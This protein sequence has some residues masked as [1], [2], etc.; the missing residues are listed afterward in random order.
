M[1]GSRVCRVGCGSGSALSITTGARRRGADLA[2][3]DGYRAVAARV[4]A[5]VTRPTKPTMPIVPVGKV[6]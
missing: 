2:P 1:S 5:G 4:G 6:V 3:R